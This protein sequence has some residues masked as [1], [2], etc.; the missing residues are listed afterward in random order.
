MEEISLTGG[1]LLSNKN[2]G[3]GVGADSQ[4]LLS[5]DEKKSLAIPVSKQLD[6]L[7]Q[8]HAAIK[9]NNVAAQ[10]N[11]DHSHSHSTGA[12]ASGGGSCP[13]HSCPQVMVAPMIG[14]KMPPAEYV[15]QQSQANI[16]GA[17]TILTKMGRYATLQ[18]ILQAWKE[19]KGADVVDA[20]L[21]QELAQHDPEGHTVLH[22]AAKRTEDLRFVQLWS[23]Y[24]PI[25]TPTTDGAGMSALHWACTEP[26]SFAIIQYLLSYQ[27]ENEDSKDAKSLT[28]AGGQPAKHNVSLL[29]LKDGSGCTPLLLAAQHGH[30]ETVAFLV[31]QYHA[32]LDALDDNGDSATHW[33]AYKGSPSVLGLLAYY[34]RQSDSSGNDDTTRTA[35]TSTS[36]YHND[37]VY[38]RVSMLTK[39]DLYGQTPL[40]L[41]ALR[42]HSVACQYILK[43]ICGPKQENRRAALQLLALPDKNGR[44]PYE[45]AVHKK[46]PHTAI[47]LQQAERTLQILGTRNNTMQARILFHTIVVDWLCSAHRWK[48]WLG[49]PTGL[50]DP[51][52]VAPSFPKYY[53]MFSVMLNIWYHYTVFL[54]IFDMGRGVLW[55]CTTLHVLQSMLSVVCTFSLYKCHTTNPGTMDETFP[56]I[57]YWRRLYGET[58]AS[59]ADSTDTSTKY[60]LCHTCHIA[61]PLRSKHDRATGACVLLFDHNCPFVGNTI[62][63]Y[64]YKWFYLFLLTL[65][66]YFVDHIV[67]FAKY[68]S[69]VNY[70]ASWW[71]LGLGV[72]LPMHILMSGFLLIYHTQ[73]TMLNLTTN[74]HVNLQKYDY[75]WT[76]TTTTTT[77]SVKPTDDDI[78]QGLPAQQPPVVNR[79]YKNPWNKGILRNFWDRFN[80]SH[81]C[82]M[83]PEGKERLL[84]SSSSSSS[85]T[86]YHQSNKAMNHSN[87]HN[88]SI[89]M[90]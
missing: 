6:V 74:E 45:L 79:K 14:L 50:D 61:R 26:N 20:I 12:G 27:P 34:E 90:I 38:Q 54:P 19:Y 31:H 39:P 4:H 53:V 13:L 15:R 24:I 66:W 72:F 7:N 22:W 16:L 1:T 81:S 58:L 59:Y 69:R 18:D 77:S 33:A 86:P 43:H 64:N 73:L 48:T 28:F 63:L 83:L 25:T 40:H 36:S 2:Q 42:G 82:Y 89:Q 5:G 71:T 35:A 29:E 52:E 80:P 21:R 78:E 44:T 46:K 11:H 56:E 32:R 60:Q 65:T 37:L 70:Q 30:V 62:G 67:L 84:S 23:R 47:R 87:N 76:T 75:L 55:D 68:V 9:G 49:I 51:M 17:L 41:A 3:I 85:S 88:G 8:Y 10:H 57:G